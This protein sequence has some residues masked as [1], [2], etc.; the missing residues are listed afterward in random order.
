MSK[1]NNALNKNAVIQLENTAKKQRESNLNIEFSTADIDTSIL[2]FIITKNNF[3]LLLGN[4]NVKTSIVLIHSEGLK[5][6]EELEITDG[7]NG[8]VSYKIPN[9]MVKVPGKVTA[10]VYVA[11]KSK[12]KI[13]AL[14]AERI[15]SF[16]IAKS[17]A[18]EFDAET[19]L[20]YIVE[21][22]ELE[23][24][25]KQRAYAIEQSMANGEDYVSKIEKAK[26]EGLSD[27]EIAKTDSLNELN[28]LVSNKLNE[29]NEKGSQYIE[30]L[31]GLRDGIDKKTDQ[32]NDDVDARGYV[33]ESDTS[34]WQKHKLTDDTG[35][36]LTLE[37][38]DFMKPDDVIK[39]SGMYF[40]KKTKSGPKNE[41]E[42]GYIISNVLNDENISLLFNPINSY[43]QYILQKVDGEWGT[44]T[45]LTHDAETIEGAQNKANE[46]YEKAKEYF[47]NERKNN[48]VSLWKGNAN[49]K[50]TIIKLN[51]SYKNYKLLL[52]VYDM[53]EHK[54][55]IIAL[56]DDFG[57]VNIH[58]FNLS[59]A[60]GSGARLFEAVLVSEG[61]N[62]LKVK[63]NNSYNVS[64]N[65]GTPNAKLIKIKEIVGVK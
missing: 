8:K 48:Y 34:D 4:D 31:T 51:D 10:Q 6:K 56:T 23:A 53:I 37:E 62:Q 15:F 32:F 63:H 13:H 36:S 18:W 2:E 5:I 41:I 52:V 38:F 12:D 42:S 46:S 26:N 35:N 50:D 45:D 9:E 54:K 22:D 25:L 58:D 43:K 17:L 44:T 14:V 64:S 27:I 20:N 39:K 65:T 3:P 59:D 55:D 19:K 57:G 28:T 33:K 1:Y 47:D 61:D 24:K 21:F 29:I 7:L 30:E 16:S 60:D 40:V 11:R 49:E